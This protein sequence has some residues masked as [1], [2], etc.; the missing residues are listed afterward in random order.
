[1]EAKIIGIS[2]EDLEDEAMIKY[3]GQVK[4]LYKDIIGIC[5]RYLYVS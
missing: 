3:M 5:R 2:P 1:M 4:D